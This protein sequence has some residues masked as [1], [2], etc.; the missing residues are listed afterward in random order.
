[1]QVAKL[2][3]LPPSAVA[4]AKSVLSRLEKTQN[5]GRP[6]ALDDLPLF[7]A[8]SPAQEAVSTPSTLEQALLDLDPDQLTPREALDFV[9]ALKKML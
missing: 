3:G 7:A 6:G 2:A 1:V 8:T 5:N 4:R 9:Y